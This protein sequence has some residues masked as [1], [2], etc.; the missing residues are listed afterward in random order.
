MARCPQEFDI[1][2]LMDVLRQVSYRERKVNPE[3]SGVADFYKA[4]LDVTGRFG[5]L[6]EVGLT[7]IYKLKRFPKE[8]MNDV[9]L[10]PGMM[11]RNKLHLIPK[12]I[13]GASQVRKIIDRCMKESRG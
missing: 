4:F 2:G 10:A 13:K 3:G 6:S 7:A 1:A 11:S 9:S 8:I 12:R 5:R